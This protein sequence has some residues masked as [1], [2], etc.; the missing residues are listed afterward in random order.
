MEGGR[1]SIQQRAIRIR[2]IIKIGDT[3]L[4]KSAAP[5]SGGSSPRAWGT[6]NNGVALCKKCH[7]KGGNKMPEKKQVIVKCPQCGKGY[8]VTTGASGKSRCGLCGY[9]GDTSEFLQPKG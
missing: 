7:L 8:K 2:N 6:S 4:N 5:E 9:H 1:K 3:G